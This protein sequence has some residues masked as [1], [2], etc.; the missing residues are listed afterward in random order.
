MKI[1]LI[2][3]PYPFSEFPKPS[4]A[5]MYLGAVLKQGGVTV[6]LLDLLST[7]FSLNKVE[8][9]LTRFQP[10]LIGATSVTMNFPKAVQ[11]L[12][13]CKKV[14]PTS[15]IVMGGPHVTFL[16]EETLQAFPEIDVIVRGEGEE[17]IQELALSL[18]RREDWGRIKGITFRHN[19]SI[20]RNEDRPFIE[21][22]DRLPLPDRTLFPLSRYL[23]MHVPASVLTSRG[24]P[25]GC[26]FCV[27]YRMT[28]RQGRF[29]DPRRVA[30]EM[31]NA[32]RLGFSEI[33]ID[34]DLFTRNRKHVLR[35]CEEI[36]QRGLR[37]KLYLFP[38]IP[39]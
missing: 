4:S 25:T 33:C 1:L 17:T 3:P 16:S 29:R 24:C 36:A 22:L 7:R 14:S 8:K 20:I 28:G 2:Q 15:K 30:D 35:I 38:G 11:I 31:E 39:K 12:Q 18:D 13:F 37:L 5:L 21:N 23:A 27:G 6:E 34:D 32:H 10:D 19:G 9:A 26:S